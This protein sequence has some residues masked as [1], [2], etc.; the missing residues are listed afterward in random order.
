M[1]GWNRGKTLIDWNE[2]VYQKFGG[3]F[4]LVASELSGN[5]ER[6]LTI[7]CVKCGTEKSVSSIS[8]RGKCARAGHCEVCSVK[9]TATEK[10][11]TEQKQKAKKINARIK[12]RLATKQIGFRFCECGELIPNNRQLCDS[13]KAEH[14]KQSRKKQTYKYCKE[15][16]YKAEKKREAR[17]KGVKRDRDATLNALYKK[18]NGTCYLCGGQCDWSDGKWEHGVFKVGAHY[19]SREHIIPIAKGGDDTWSN[20]RL[21]HVSC[22]A[23]KGT[24]L[25]NLYP[26]G[27]KTI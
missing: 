2:K 19:P 20:L 22:N 25:L 10:A 3:Q 9:T 8:F 21:A 15:I 17:L 14:L 12:R 4:E 5:G 23:K 24:K 26:L 13:C 27:V 6:M 7:R 1:G 11:I 18:Y 16:W